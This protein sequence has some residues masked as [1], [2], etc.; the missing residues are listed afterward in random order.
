MTTISWRQAWI[1]S[2]LISAFV[3]LVAVSYGRS[4]MALLLVPTVFLSANVAIRL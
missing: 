1:Y 4:K 3:M 2:L